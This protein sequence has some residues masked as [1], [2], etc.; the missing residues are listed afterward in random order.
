MRRDTHFYDQFHEL[1]NSGVKVSKV[2]QIEFNSGSE[3]NIHLVC[4]ALAAKLMLQEEYC[5]SSEV[6][7]PNGE[8]DLLAWGH[9]EKLSYAI[10]FEHSPTEEVKASKLERY[11]TQTPIDDMLLLN[12]NECPMNILEIEDWLRKELGI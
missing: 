4:K 5:I 6:E 3:T 7:V 2:N 9:P 1:D 8:I 10:E 12:L 11:I